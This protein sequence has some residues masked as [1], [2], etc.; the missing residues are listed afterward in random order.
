MD[1]SIE[2]T[3]K[4]W[5]DNVGEA[6]L[7]EELDALVAEDGD[8]LYDAFYRSLAFGTAGLRGTLGV[9]TNRMNV[10]VVAQATQGVADYLNAHYENP[11][12]ALA[13]DSRLKGEDFQKVAAGIL[14]ANGIHVYVYPR[15]EPV[16][17][18]PSPCAT[19][20]PPRASS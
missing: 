1:Q 16:P 2:A 15:I 13:R 5:Q 7:A 11:T 9:G 10:Y 8:K 14:A 19:W 4:A 6:D 3:V 12:L 18:R 20:A 17:T